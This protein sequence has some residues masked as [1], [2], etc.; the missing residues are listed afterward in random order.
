MHSRAASA[1]RILP[2]NLC[3]DSSAPAE[4][5]SDPEAFVNLTVGVAALA[6]LV[7][8]LLLIGYHFG[9]PLPRLGFWRTLAPLL[10]LP[11]GILVGVV[12]APG[13]LL[14][15]D[16]TSWRRR[17]GYALAGIVVFF[18]LLALLNLPTV[19]LLGS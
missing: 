17:V 7:T 8:A 2:S 9:G 4:T 5:A 14:R 11:S 16:A 3:P 10:L 1:E 13:G 18:L 15:D 12:L 6:L 19:L